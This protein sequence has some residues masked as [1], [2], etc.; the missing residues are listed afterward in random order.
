MDHAVPREPVVVLFVGR[1][2]GRVG[3]VAQELT[4]QVGRNHT[5]HGQLVV[6][7]ALDEHRRVV[8][9]EVG[10]EH[11]ALLA[12]KVGSTGSAGPGWDGGRS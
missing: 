9:S 8:A 3:A 10:I 2:E 6:V 11:S 7:A 4:G 1:D 12:T 5:G